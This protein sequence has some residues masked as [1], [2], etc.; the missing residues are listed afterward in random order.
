MKEYERICVG[1]IRIANKTG[2]KKLALIPHTEKPAPDETATAI[3]FLQML[4]HKKKQQAEVSGYSVFTSKNFARGEMNLL[5]SAD[6]SV[7]FHLF[8]VPGVDD[9]ISAVR[10]EHLD[11]GGS[12]RRHIHFQLINQKKH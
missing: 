1:R 3:E 11:A 6:V 2:N 10:H 12:E 7:V 8:V 4:P 5:P 9:E